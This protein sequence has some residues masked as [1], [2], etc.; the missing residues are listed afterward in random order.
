MPRRRR[1]LGAKSSF[2]CRAGTGREESPEPYGNPYNRGEVMRDTSFG[3]S[4]AG[5]IHLGERMIS[6]R[7]GEIRELASLQLVSPWECFVSYVVSHCFDGVVIWHALS[8][9]H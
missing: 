9:W 4:D 7:V 5:D 6:L 1:K 8:E 2:G 3:V